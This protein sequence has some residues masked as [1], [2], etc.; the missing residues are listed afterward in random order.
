M[1]SAGFGLENPAY[2]QKRLLLGKQQRE[3]K[4][5]TNANKL[6]RAYDREKAYGVAK[7][8]KV[9]YSN[10]WGDGRKVLDNLKSTRYGNV[11]AVNVKGVSPTLFNNQV[12]AINEIA[13]KIPILDESLK[14][15]GLVI[16]SSQIKGVAYTTMRDDR[17]R[18]VF[19]TETLSAKANYK[20]DVWENI[21]SGYFMP[22]TKSGA[23]FYPTAH[24]LGHILQK[25]IV[26]KELGANYT[27]WQYQKMADTHKKEILDI[28]KSNKAK[29][30]E[31]AKENSRD[32]FAECFANLNC[33]K[34]NAY[35]LALSEFLEKRG[36]P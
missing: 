36:L 10:S 14:K 27:D 35:G 30:S 16:T 32:F 8:P 21:K 25:S 7:Q 23:S 22:A 26:E 3:L 28:V 11:K 4:A 19:N 24:E 29:L 13:S 5:W 17:L 18:V 1:D 15:Y 9:L 20:A 33:G 6:P 12:K 31:Y 34:P 2:V